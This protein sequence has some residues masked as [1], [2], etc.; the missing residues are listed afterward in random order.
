M[1]GKNPLRKV[2]TS[3]GESLLVH[4]VFGTIQG[5]GPYSG[6]PAIFV[7]LAGC[8][9]ACYFCDTEFEEGA[10]Q[11]D[12][13]DLFAAIENQ[14]DE[15]CPGASLIVLTGGEP[16]RQPIG[17]FMNRAIHD[18]WRVQIETAGTVWPASKNDWLYDL[19][20]Y[21]ADKG[22]MP[23]ITLVCSP[24]TGK[25]HPK[26]QDL[27]WNWKYLIADGETD[28]DGFPNTSTQREGAPLRIFRPSGSD[29]VIW[30]Q[31]RE[32]YQTVNGEAVPDVLA[33]RANMQHAAALAMK[34]GRRL[35][36]QTHKILDL[37]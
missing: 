34:H 9:L 32:D 28:E 20:W 3:S 15:Y 27:C 35:T 11:L 14:R 1:F 13:D 19:G 16:M 36:L 24:K 7:R 33:T 23:P 37:P 25:V 8:N 21:A 6:M 22:E 30:Y 26:V 5:E 12:L 4:S 10:T 2:D 17:P 29:H 31:P 18:G